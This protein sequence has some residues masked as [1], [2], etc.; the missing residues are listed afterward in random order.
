MKKIVAILTLM[1]CFSAGLFASEYKFVNFEVGPMTGFPFYGANE[2]YDEVQAVR[3]DEGVR[4]VFGATGDMRFDLMPEFS[5]YLG[6]D[7]LSDFVW[8]KSEYSN[9][10]DY[11]F[12]FGGK[13]Y[14]TNTGFSVNIAYGSGSRSDYTG[15][16]G[17][18]NAGAS[19]PQ[20]PSYAAYWGNGF[21]LGFEYD[22]SRNSNFKHMPVVGAYWKNMPRGKNLR[23]STL[24][25]AAKLGF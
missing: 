14:P 5:L 11:A 20:K 22:F 18:N 23:D 16:K 10:L 21:K 13:V 3:D 1:I 12:F 2:L 24:S 15:K 25:F 19:A 4:L 8:N 7:I 9:H 6:V 17:D